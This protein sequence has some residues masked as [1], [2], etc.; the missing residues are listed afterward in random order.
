[1]ALKNP[2]SD[3]VDF[4][5]TKSA[6]GVTLTKGTNL[7]ASRMLSVDSAPDQAVFCLNT[8]GPSPTPYLGGGRESWYRPTVQVMFRGPTGDPATGE[9]IARGVFERLHH[10]SVTGYTAVLRR[11]AQP[12]FLGEDG[13]QRGQWVINV[14]C[15]YK[16]ALP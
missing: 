7:F 6:G 14:E 4:L 16:A 12:A 5:T 15:Q 3:L 8:G 13:D 1:M 2:A 9:G 11:E 10:A